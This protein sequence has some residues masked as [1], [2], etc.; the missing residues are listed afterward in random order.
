ML[1]GDWREGCEVRRL[2]ADADMTRVDR[3]PPF[4]VAPG[5]FVSQNV[6]QG[7]LYGVPRNERE[8]RG[9]YD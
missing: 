7:T 6:P 1:E 5:I 9:D 4:F 8:T 2:G 3:G